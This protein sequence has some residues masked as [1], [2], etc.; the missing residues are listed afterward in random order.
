MEL[1]VHLPPTNVPTIRP[2][3]RPAP[4]VPKVAE[5]TIPSQFQAPEGTY[6]LAPPLSIFPAIG[7]PAPVPNVDRNA[8]NSAVFMMSPGA[9]IPSPQNPAILSTATSAGAY[10][11]NGRWEPAHPVKMNW[12]GVWFPSRA[13]G[14]FGGLLGKGPKGDGSAPQGNIA[15]EGLYPNASNGSSSSSSSSPQSSEP[16]SVPFAMS[17]PTAP[18]KWHF[19]KPTNAA[20]RPKTSLRGTSNLIDRVI[21]VD[22]LQRILSEKGRFGGET[23]RWGTWNMGRQWAWGEQGGKIR[24]PFAKIYFRHAVTSHAIIQQTANVDR[25]DCIVGLESGDLI[26]VDPILGRYTRLN[27]NGIL[28][29]N[30]VDGIYPD[31]RQPTHFLAVFADSTILRF[32]TS[33]EDPINASTSVLPTKPWSLFFER[34]WARRARGQSA[35]GSSTKLGGSVG[36][37]GLDG[38]VAGLS[39]SVG[40]KEEADDE[41]LKWKNEDW[42]VGVEREKGKDKGPVSFAG[43]NP[44]AAIR[45]GRDKINAMAYSPDAKLLAVASEDGNLRI[46]DIAEEHITDTYASYYGAFTCLA[47]SPNSRL[48]A[49][50]GQDDL[51]T[52]LSPND[53]RII[54]RCQGHTSYIR[55]IAFDQQMKGEARAYRF[56]SVGEDGKLIF[57]DFSPAAVHKRHHHLPTSASGHIAPA[58][59]ATVNHPQGSMSNLFQN[60]SGTYHPALPRSEVPVLQPV[61]SRLVD[62]TIVTGVHCLPDC[63]VT[64]SRYGQAKFW[65]RPGKQ[66]GQNGQ[67]K[68]TGTT[69]P[70][71]SGSM[72]KG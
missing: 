15:L 64:V 9:P 40:A 8:P 6:C 19:G 63:I 13:G 3:F 68:E 35:E 27:K 51:I 66:V 65:M 44:V 58:S 43:K 56:T 67:G 48:L 72:I 59:S 1:Y 18:S 25:L 23:A 53:G 29:N 54:A 61:M 32:N 69:T 47:W 14:S 5:A 20:P 41:L 38:S 55:S 7:S 42:T 10:Q 70:G 2:A 62:F 17:P 21:T 22:N 31:P 16:Q 11:V 4:A 12:V 24:E 26:W 45:V 71:M 57:W 52:L 37:S 28:N 34:E 39:A 33:L 46:I 60:P 49:A 50:G 36:D 30:R